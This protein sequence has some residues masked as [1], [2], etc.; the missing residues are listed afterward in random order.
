MCINDGYDI[1]D[2]EK[3]MQEFIT[4]MEKLLPE[5]SSFEL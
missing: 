3:V 2:E 1:K 4:A 5:K